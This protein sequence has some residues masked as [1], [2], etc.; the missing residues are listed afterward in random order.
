MY[1]FILAL[2][3]KLSWP[4]QPG[5][6]KFSDEMLQETNTLIS[7]FLNEQL[8]S[9]CNSV[10]KGNIGG[11]STLMHCSQDSSDRIL[12]TLVLHTVTVMLSKTNALLEPFQNILLH[13]SQLKGKYLPTMPEDPL[14]LV[15]DVMAFDGSYRE[16]YGKLFQCPN[17]HPY[18]IA[19][20][21]K[22]NERSKCPYCG[23]PIGAI[24]YGQLAEGNCEIHSD[25]R[26]EI[27]YVLGAANTRPETALPERK[28]SPMA[29]AVT[30]FILHVCY[31]WSSCHSTEV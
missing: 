23:E 19:N 27:G 14:V 17:G 20:C 29:C 5:K 11:A 10:F 28:L 18:L 13:P 26:K 12:T 31:L 15:E 4:F 1:C 21:T 16:N 7:G 2:F 30:R 24:S 3:S 9:V 6:Y 25:A 22:P 8:L